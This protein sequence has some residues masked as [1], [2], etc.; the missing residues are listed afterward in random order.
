M[1]YG[2]DAVFRFCLFASSFSVIVSSQPIYTDPE[3]IKFVFVYAHCFYL[4]MDK[5]GATLSM[6]KYI[7]NYA[8]HNW[9]CT[10]CI[11]SND[12][13]VL[14]SKL[15]FHFSLMFS[16][17]AI[18]SYAHRQVFYLLTFICY[19][20]VGISLLFSIS[21]IDNDIISIFMSSFRMQRSCTNR[22]TINS[23][24][25]W[26]ANIVRRHEFLQDTHKLWV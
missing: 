23:T 18:Y 26:C 5:I 11:L 6:Y 17:N 3:K 16:F 24:E 2:S 19:Y 21:S 1:L 10:E 25:Y 12:Y 13:P 20:L 14:I 15:I 7:Q 9:W 22:N 4:L 8:T